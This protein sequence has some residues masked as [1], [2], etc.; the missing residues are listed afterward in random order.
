LG[1]HLLISAATCVIA[2]SAATAAHLSPSL[3]IRVVP[4]GIDLSQ[5]DPA[6]NK[7][8]FRA[9]YHIP[10]DALVVGMVGRLRPWKGQVHFLQMAAQIVR[11][12]PDVRFLIVGGDIFNADAS[13]PKQLEHLAEELQLT[14]HVIFTRQVDN[15][16]EALAAMDIFVH[17]GDPEP[18]G[19]VNIEAMAMEK[20]VIAFAHGALPE[21]IVNGETGLLIAPYDT[22]ALATAVLSLLDTLPTQ[23]QMGRNGRFRVETH[24]TIQNTVQQITTLY[25]EIL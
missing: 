24:F 12:Q 1:K 13:Y 22:D 18:F 10:P 5:F 8:P 6:L 23:Q 7:R 2:N 15:V 14:N 9:Q 19:L 17:P 25:R 11:K 16:P 4:N 3:K 21:I 20:P